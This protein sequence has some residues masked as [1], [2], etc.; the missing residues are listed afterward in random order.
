MFNKKKRCLEP[1]AANC[2]KNQTLFVASGC[3]RQELVA[4]SWLPFKILIDIEYK[5][6]QEA[7]FD[8]FVQ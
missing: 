6:S 1:L 3:E 4:A 2:K 5:W 8:R 7:P